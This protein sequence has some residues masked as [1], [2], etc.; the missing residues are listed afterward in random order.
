MEVLKSTDRAIEKIHEE[1]TA[2][3]GQYT[4]QQRSTL[5]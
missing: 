4:P 5:Q 1:A 3:G 2:N